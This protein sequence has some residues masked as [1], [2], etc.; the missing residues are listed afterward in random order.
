MSSPR[1][2]IVRTDAGWH[3][4]F[5]AANGEPVMTSEIYTRRQAAVNAVEIALS[6]WAARVDPE[7]DVGPV[8]ARATK[9]GFGVDDVDERTTADTP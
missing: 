8:E 5:R 3:V 9:L 4:R 6:A 1:F 2:E 7:L